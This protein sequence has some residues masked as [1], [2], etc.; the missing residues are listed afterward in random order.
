[1]FRTTRLYLPA[2]L[3]TA[4]FFVGIVTAKG[5]VS[6]EQIKQRIID[7]SIS[8]YPG[9][10]ACPY[11]SARNGRSCG[12][13]SAWSRAGGYSPICYKKEVTQEMIKQWRD[14]H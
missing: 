9:T 3:L 5:S 6:D 11:N 10:C 12:G 8:A 13:R 14:N 1:M 7:H 2:V 4:L